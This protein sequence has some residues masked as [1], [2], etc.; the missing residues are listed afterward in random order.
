MKGRGG[1]PL[2]L[3]PQRGPGQL[4]VSSLITIRRRALINWLFPVDSPGG[5]LLAMFNTT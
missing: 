2:F 3:V 4:E 1:S 5:R